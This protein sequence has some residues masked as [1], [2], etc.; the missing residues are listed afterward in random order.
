M[1]P[2]VAQYLQCRIKGWLLNNE[3]GRIWKEEAVAWFE[4]LSMGL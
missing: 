4:T 3:L 1:T 2:S